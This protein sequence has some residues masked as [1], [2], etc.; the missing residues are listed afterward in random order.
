MIEAGLIAARFVHY[1]AL[2]LAFGAFA[3]A[4]FGDRAEPIVSRRLRRLAVASSAAV[5]V[6]A[7]AVLAATTAGLAGGYDALADASLWSTVLLETDFGQVWSARLLA[8]LLLTSALLGAGTKR[9]VFRALGL[10]TAGALLVSVA[11]TGHAQIETGWPGRIH[12]VAD[13]L[14]LAAAGLWLGALA[15]LLY[16][17]SAR[18]P[19]AHS[20]KVAAERLV[21][22][23]NV[24]LVAVLVLVGTGL[25]NSWFLV[26]T[27][28]RLLDTAYGQVLLIK[29]AL[30][31]AMIALAAGNRLR[32][33][34]AL[35]RQAE[36]CGDAAAALSRLR[37][38][39]KAEL[40]LGVLVLLAVAVLGAIAPAAETAVAS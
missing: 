39:V 31:A 4:G 38:Q 21:A 35:R 7:V 32:H 18:L 1:I 29:L 2:V 30:F 36:A 9:G 34:P 23:H 25:V 6:A 13:A 24:G 40:I 22:F 14:H 12:R 33:V 17:L 3:Y 15:P 28:A 37:R 5:L 8:A 20:A 19:P 11:L 16:L 10:L 26:G 27:P